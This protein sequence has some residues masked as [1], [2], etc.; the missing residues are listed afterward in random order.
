MSNTLKDITI[1]VPSL[2]FKGSTDK[3]L[4]IPIELNGKRKEF[5]ESDRTRNIDALEQSETERNESNIYRI[6]GKVTEIFSNLLVGITP[7]E[8]FKNNMF[9]INQVEV[10]E[11]NDILFNDFGERVVDT[12]GLKWSGYPQYDEFSMIRYDRNNSHF[13][14]QPKSASTYNWGVY[15][16]YVFSSN[17]QQSMSYF[18]SE[19]SGNTLDFIASDG[20]PFTIINTVLNG[21][22]YITFRCGG[23]HNLTPYQYVELSIDYNGNR[24][25]QVEYIGEAGFSNTET[26]FSIY[27]PG[28]T[29]TTF[30]NG[31]VGTFKRISDITN[32]GESRSEYYV[33]LHKV[34]TNE[35]GIVVSKMG[36]EN[37]P[38]ATK[39]QVEYS[40]LTP[41]LVER[42]ST[43]DGSQ[44]YSFSVV[45]DINISNL[46]TTYN[47][48]LTDLYLT[49]INKG[50]SGWFNKPNPDAGSALQ[51]GWDFNFN[52]QTIDEWW[53]TNNIDSYENIPTLQYNKTDSFGTY[54]FY[55]NQPLKVDD[56]LVGDFCEY[57]KLEQIE[58]TISKCNHKLTFN[59]TL[60]QIESQTTAIPEG[61]FYKPF[62][63]IKLRDYSGS[64]SVQ[65]Q[66]FGINRPNWAYFSQNQQLWY[67]RELLKP[68]EIEI[69][70]NGV[71]Y[72]FLNGGHYTFTPI[73]FLLSTPFKNINQSFV[74]DETPIID[75]CE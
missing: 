8:G 57:N 52:E 40:A 28:F 47:R 42:I 26:S 23:K 33:K 9:L 72:P 34:I 64:L 53:S 30:Q 48:P 51:Y 69:D 38:F 5:I 13:T 32:S 39:K 75:D 68:G 67:W 7:Y 71:N 49:I 70:G 25:F 63:E 18:D 66:T 14:Y 43:L 50:Y 29:G 56:I 54:V 24:L 16:S 19:L 11:N 74:N 31:V 35:D 61:Y 3:L 27:N 4:S 36:F 46:K 45:N 60:Y 2:Q 41:N 37:N 73:N 44:T 1:V 65:P 59:D 12:F 20:I 22:K 62:Y 17:T 58:I 55:Y 10:L 21:K 15:L 6:G